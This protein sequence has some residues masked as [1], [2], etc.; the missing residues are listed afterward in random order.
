MV[1]SDG[2][3]DARRRVPCARFRGEC[4]RGLAL[5]A[6]A[7]WADTRDALERAPRARLFRPPAAPRLR[8]ARVDLRACDEVH[9]RWRG[10]VRNPGLRYAVTHPHK[11]W[12]RRARLLLSLYVSRLRATR[13][14][15]AAAPATRG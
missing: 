8:L 10:R 2:H 6:A 5:A 3:D 14:R 7:T 13:A 11:P 9:S 12:W 15:D 4:V 1:V